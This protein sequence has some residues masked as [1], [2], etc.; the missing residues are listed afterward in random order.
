MKI[1][2][3]SKFSNLSNWKEETWKNQGFNGIRTHDL[4]DTGA[5]ALPTELWN[6][7]LGVR[8][9][10][11]VHFFPYSEVMWSIYEIIHSC[12]A[13][14]DEVKI[15]TYIYIYNRSTTMN[16]FIYTSHHFTVREK[17]TQQTDL[18]PSSDQIVVQKSVIEKD[19]QLLLWAWTNKM[20]D[21]I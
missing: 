4:R 3:R 18:T 16:Y 7:T 21:K 5:M 8:S 11:W 20:A 14:V 12:T 9:V 1:D 2:H 10:C 6:H 19:W 15:Y 13:V 17:W